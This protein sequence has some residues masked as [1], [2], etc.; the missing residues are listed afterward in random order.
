MTFFTLNCGVHADKRKAGQ[1]MVEEYV[2]TP[3][4]L[5]MTIVTLFTLLA[6]VYI[7]FFVTLNTGGLQLV[8]FSFKIVL[9]FQVKVAFVAICTGQVFVLAPEWKV[10]FFIMIE[11]VLL[12]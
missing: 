11:F 8:F 12:P 9:F 5:V 6:L 2:V 3:A 1:V 7:I 10:C 4:F